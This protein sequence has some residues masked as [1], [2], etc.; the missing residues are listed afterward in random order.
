MKYRFI[1]WLFLTLLPLQAWSSDDDWYSEG[2]IDLVERFY[3][4]SVYFKNLTGIG[5]SLKSDYLEQSSF[6]LGGNI[7]VKTYKSGLNNAPSD[8]QEIIGYISSARHQYLDKYPGKLSVRLDGYLGIDR[9]SGLSV[10]SSGGMSSNTR[11]ITIS[12]QFFV[13]STMVS[14]LNNDKSFYWDLGAAYSQFSAGDKDQNIDIVN[15]KKNT[16]TNPS[17]AEDIHV[18]QWTP[19]IAFG[20]NNGMDWIQLR[21]Y[22]IL[23]SSSD[24]VAYKKSSSAM[25]AKWIHWFSYDAFLGLNSVNLTI[26][27]GE[28]IYAVDNDSYSLYNTSDMQKNSL[29]LG[30]KWK[31]GEDKA[32]Y[33]HLGSEQYEDLGENSNYT[34]NYV[35]AQISKKW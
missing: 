2:S 19:T 1:S 32:F 7:N 26:L 16:L 35:F 9:Y 20:L 4:D 5:A 18:T 30:A 14:Y 34:S 15:P 22:S 21:A 12:D 6:V 29:S 10:T 3:S 23:F 17:S 31:Y 33:L 25:E 11:N 28:R 27:A 24:R 13:I 8:M